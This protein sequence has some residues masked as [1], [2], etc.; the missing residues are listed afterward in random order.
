MKSAFV[1][2]I[3]KLK[4]SSY[5]DDVRVGVV[6][7]AGDYSLDNS[8]IEFD[9]I[10]SIS[11]LE[12]IANSNFDCAKLVQ[13]E[14]EHISRG[15]NE[16]MQAEEFS[17]WDPIKQSFFIFDQNPRDN[18]QED[19]P[20][21]ILLFNSGNHLTDPTEFDNA[22]R[23]N[24]IKKVVVNFGE[25]PPHEIFNQVVGSPPLEA[26]NYPGAAIIPPLL[27]KLEEFCRK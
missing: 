25:D 7:A 18:L 9:D 12:R 2:L 10:N 27:E 19:C 15:L 16:A 21:V 17:S 4:K 22:F 1:T 24:D 3:K 20:Q 14:T 11:D 8:R 26:N 13:R 6:F 23:D 5:N